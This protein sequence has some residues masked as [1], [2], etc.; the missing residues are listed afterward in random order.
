[1]KEFAIALFI[2]ALFVAAMLIL[3]GTW[4]I[5]GLS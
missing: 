1:M 3:G 5:G 2:I 4:H